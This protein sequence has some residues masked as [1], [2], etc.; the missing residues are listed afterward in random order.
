VYKDTSAKGT[1]EAEILKDKISCASMS[2]LPQKSMV[3]YLNI[4]NDI[5][6]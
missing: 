1:P 4:D 6:L 3:L 5:F 2:T